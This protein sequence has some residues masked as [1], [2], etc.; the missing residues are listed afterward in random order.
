MKAF[1]KDKFI[2]IKCPK[3]GSTTYVTVL[4]KNGWQEIN[5]FENNLNYNNYLLWGH[6]INPEIR[7]TKGI[8]QYLRINPGIDYNNPSIAKMLVSAVFDEHTYSLNMML[9]PLFFLPVYWIPLDAEI[10]NWNHPDTPDKLII[11]NGDDLTNEFFKENNIDIVVS[12][13]DHLNDGGDIDKLLKIQIENY[14]KQY[15]DNYQ[16]LVKNFLEP[17]IILYNKILKK[18][19]I[20]YGS[21][22]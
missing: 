4:K 18:F 22:E 5:L 9:G 12:S 21:D 14:K 3:N 7:H 17:D 1:V 10:T 19:R 2:Y 15:Q 11:H 16:R 8:S 6:L 20:K 13:K